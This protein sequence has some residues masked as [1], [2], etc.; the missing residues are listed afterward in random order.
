MLRSLMRSWCRTSVV[1]NG[2]SSGS[3]KSIMGLKY[4]PDSCELL[5]D[6]GICFLLILRAPFGFRLLLAQF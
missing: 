4:P 6:V 2:L 5:A 1:E 3:V